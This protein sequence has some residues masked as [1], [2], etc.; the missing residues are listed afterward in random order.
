[1][2]NYRPKSCCLF[3]TGEAD[4]LSLGQPRE[5][6][7]G[8]IAATQ[9]RVLAVIARDA[10]VMAWDLGVVVNPKNER[11]EWK[12][13]FQTARHAVDRH[14]G[15]IATTMKAMRRLNVRGADV[16]IRPV[17]GDGEDSIIKYKYFVLDDITEQ[18]ARQIAG[19]NRALVIRT[20]IEGGCQVWVFTEE[21]LD[22]RDRLVV[23]QH[24]QRKLVAGGADS[25]AVSGVQFSRMPG[26]KNY[27]RG[28]Q[29]VN[30]LLW[31]RGKRLSV[32][33][34]LPN[35]SKASATSAFQGGAQKAPFSRAKA[36]EH[37]LIGRL[38]AEIVRAAKLPGDTTPSGHEWRAC[39]ALL[40][41]GCNPDE[42]INAL[43]QVSA[44]RKGRGA[45][46]YAG[47]T[48]AK[49]CLEK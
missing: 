46:Q 38:R 1:M 6:H 2:K 37:E 16:Y 12:W 5:S 32:A 43:A 14:H 7:V 17:A 19:Q 8:G 26:F 31:P 34:I 48:V 4:R 28:G 3:S 30:V 36:A 33:H 25:G 40:R 47:R 13:R 27:K 42:L 45:S 9:L 10:G 20:S 49:L 22:R 41:S 15:G 39:A 35:N 18:L 29:W 44:E 11:A 24:F 23:Q 21:L